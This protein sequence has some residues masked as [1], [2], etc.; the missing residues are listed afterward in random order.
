M[1]AGVFLWEKAEALSRDTLY[2]LK[3]FFVFN[4]KLLSYE[5]FVWSWSLDDVRHIMKYVT[6]SI[7]DDYR[8]KRNIKRRAHET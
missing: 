1:V 3:G 2:T 7:S 6:P 5:L 4:L 8:V